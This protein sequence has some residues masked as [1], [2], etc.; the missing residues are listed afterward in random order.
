MSSLPFTLLPPSAFQRYDCAGCGECCRGRFAIGVTPEEQARI[1]AQGWGDDPA[2]A[3]KTLFLPHGDRYV[4]A[5]DAQGACVFLDE[6]GLCRIHAK[7]GEPAKPLACRVYPFR[8][9]PSGTQVRVGI[10]FDCPEAACNRGRTLPEH[11]PAMRALLPLVLPPHAAD[12]PAPPLFGRVALTWEQLIRITEAFD[13]LLCT[14]SLDLTRRVAGCLNLS[15]LLRNPRLTELDDAAFTD[16]LKKV[17]GKVGEAAAKDELRRKAP[18]GMARVA[19][20]QLLGVYARADHRGAP[21]SLLHRISVSLRL[22]A[23]RGVVPAVQPDFPA[24]PFAALEDTFGTPTGGVAE[25]LGRYLRTHLLSMSFCG[26]AFYGRAFLDGLDSLLFTYPLLLWFT[27]LYSAGRGNTT[28]DR[29]AAE[30]A[31]ELVDHQHGISPILNLPTER[32]RLNFLCERTILR[33]L[34]VWYG[35]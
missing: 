9:I 8:F 17:V 1:T 15:A 6:R 10:R 19:F 22:L 33:S 14:A 29:A 7:F 26:V 31:I 13:S 25:V 24:V 4:T 34:V 3:G 12:L 35:S 23:G 32:A 18:P 21:P 2:L 27:R 28:L 5:Y 11:L 20:R 16:F 30:R